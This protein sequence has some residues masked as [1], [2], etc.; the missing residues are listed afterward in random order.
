M[1]AGFAYNDVLKNLR[2]FEIRARPELFS[3]W[4]EGVIEVSSAGVERYTNDLS[5]REASHEYTHLGNCIFEQ[6]FHKNNSYK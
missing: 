3:C 1:F 2:E 6:N 5:I 4:K